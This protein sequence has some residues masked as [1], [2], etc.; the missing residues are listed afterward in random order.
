MA[1]KDC[2][3]RRTQGDASHILMYCRSTVPT[4]LQ[5]GVIPNLDL[6]QP[7][8][9]KGNKAK[10][11]WHIHQW[12]CSLGSTNFRHE[13][14]ELLH[15]CIKLRNGPHTVDYEE[16]T[17]CCGN[18]TREPHA[19]QALPEKLLLLLRRQAPRQKQLGMSN[20]SSVP[21]AIV[22][23]WHN[24]TH[25]SFPATWWLLSTAQALQIGTKLAM[26]QMMCIRRYARG[27]ALRISP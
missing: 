26:V 16:S 22:F 1:L 3:T 14:Q 27:A 19:R 17:C 12:T 24:P 15:S 18:N 7:P 5:P 23:T 2:V 20:N 11:A 13:A 8:R 9:P 4:R 21:L 10:A 25:M 6:D